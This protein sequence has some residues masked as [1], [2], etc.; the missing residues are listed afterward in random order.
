[1]AQIVEEKPKLRV[2]W[3]KLIGGTVLTALAVG[4]GSFDMYNNVV[5]GMEKSVPIAGT[6]VIA[7]IGLLA[8]P[9]MA[10]GR[11]CTWDVRVW[12]FV[13]VCG[14][15]SLYAGFKNH[16]TSQRNHDMAQ[17][18]IATS[19]NQA[20]DAIKHAEND[21]ALAKV[22]IAN[23]GEMMGSAELSQALNTAT[24][25]YED[26]KAIC[27]PVCKDAREKVQKL[28]DRVAAAKAKEDAQARARDAQARMDREK[29]KAPA[30]PKAAGESA[31][32]E[33]LMS[34][35]LLLATIVGAT[36]FE[37]GVAYVREAVAYEMPKKVRV[38]KKPGTVEKPVD[39]TA[40][41]L[42]GF[43]AL[44][45]HGDP[46][47]Q[48]DVMASLTAWWHATG[49]KGDVPSARALGF[50]LGKAGFEKSEDRNRRVQYAIKLPETGLKLVAG[51]AN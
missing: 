49:Q 36:F 44:C 28:P 45:K 6:F 5:F 23:I 13:G 17:A 37:Q 15:L 43:I 24:K 9:A 32:E 50:A 34:I 31:Q 48:K 19:Y 1:M 27:G 10:K 40:R 14:A 26:N 11:L 3:G 30:A 41:G 46:I 12:F 21:L 2:N 42:P 22:E 29:A 25:L 39:T 47:A 4:C 8:L 16:M 20:Q 35:L 51:L 7:A 33:A 38:V 18:A